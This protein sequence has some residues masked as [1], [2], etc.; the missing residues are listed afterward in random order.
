MQESLT[1][2]FNSH[3]VE[4][5]DEQE[6]IGFS[7]ETSLAH[8]QT[9]T[10]FQKLM[11]LRGRS[12]NFAE[13]PVYDIQ[14]YPADYFSAFSPMKTFIKWA[15]L[16]TTDSTNT[17]ESL[18]KLQVSGGRYLCFSME[19]REPS[20]FFTQLYNSWFPQSVYELDNRP[21]FDKMWPDKTKRGNILKQEVYIPIK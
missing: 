17:I 4:T 13:D 20:D 12:K 1:D 2:I 10:I 14:L 3:T 19:G 11:P 15:A 7:T 18:Q 8:D 9:M 6:F 21:H 5:Y 16:N